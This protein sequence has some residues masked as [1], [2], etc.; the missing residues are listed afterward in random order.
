VARQD[1]RCLI[2]I[3]ALRIEDAH[4][5]MLF[6][7][8]CRVRLHNSAGNFNGASPRSLRQS[9]D[10]FF[11]PP[12]LSNVSTM[13][14]PLRP[15]PFPFPLAQIFPPRNVIRFTSTA[16]FFLPSSSRVRMPPYN[17]L[18]SLVRVSFPLGNTVPADVT[19]YFHCAACPRL[20]K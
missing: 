6:F 9:F 3:T 4:Q 16:L 12:L 19:Q 1:G 14:P 5:A 7:G 17:V 2:C 13:N 8:T 20:R 15:L 11:F 18:R 10:V